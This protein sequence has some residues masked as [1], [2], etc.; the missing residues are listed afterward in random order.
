MT[1]TQKDNEDVNQTHQ[2][3]KQDTNSSD[4]SKIILIILSVVLVVAIVTGGGYLIYDQLIKNDSSGDPNDSSNQELGIKA[5][6]L[7]KDEIN[8]LES[9]KQEDLVNELEN[10]VFYVARCM[11]K[12]EAQIEPIKDES[13]FYIYLDFNEAIE[14]QPDGVNPIKVAE[15]YI[16]GPNDTGDSV[17]ARKQGEKRWNCYGLPQP[18]EQT[19]YELVFDSSYDAVKSNFATAIPELGVEITLNMNQCEI[20]DHI[21][22]ASKPVPSAQNTPQAEPHQS[23]PA[24]P[25]YEDEEDDDFFNDEENP[26]SQEAPNNSRESYYSFRCRNEDIIGNTKI[27]INP[28]VTGGGWGFDT[29]NE[30]MADAQVEDGSPVNQDSKEVT[31]LEETFTKTTKELEANDKKYI[32]VYFSNTDNVHMAQ[33]AQTDV[34]LGFEISYEVNK[35]K[36]AQEVIQNLESIITSMEF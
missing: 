36:D 32:E 1:K 4:T 26:P 16:F 17:L 34:I 27:L 20:L 7:Q 35:E 21:G 19:I 11:S 29:I 6:D 31:I 24:Q 5:V 8:E 25:Q 30:G 28:V 10:T 3:Q 23:Q 12:T 33:I 18:K 2:N 14:L 15:L 22:T 13:M 9:D